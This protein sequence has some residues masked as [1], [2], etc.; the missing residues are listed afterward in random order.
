M[1]K[2]QL[3]SEGST[4]F[5]VPHYVSPKAMPRRL[6]AGYHRSRARWVSSSLVISFLTWKMMGWDQISEILSSSKTAIIALQ[7]V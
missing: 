4:H 7:M 2:R 5:L 1:K 6:F 3:H